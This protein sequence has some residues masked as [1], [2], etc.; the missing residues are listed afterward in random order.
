MNK[1]IALLLV[2]LM[3]VLAPL[4]IV[5]LTIGTAVSIVWAGSQVLYSYFLSELNSRKSK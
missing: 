3:W 1:I 4:V 5:I 2:I